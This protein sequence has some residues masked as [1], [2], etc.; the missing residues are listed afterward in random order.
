[1]LSDWLHWLPDLL[2]GLRTSI[3]A[4]VL[5][6][7]IGLPGGFILGLGMVARSP[8]M[9]YLTVS[10][11]ELGRGVP[12]LVVLYLVYFGLPAQGLVLSPFVAAIAGIA[13]STAAYTSEIFR[14]GIMN[15]P[16]GHLEAAQSLGL[17]WRDEVR[18]VVGPQA[19]RAITPALMSY[20]II[21]FQATSLGYAISLPELLTAGYGIGSVTFKFLS[22]FLL[23]GI[24]YAAVSISA[25]HLINRAHLRTSLS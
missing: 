15:V 6:L 10:V 12:L 24:L 18:F 25:S 19:L 2:A 7:L 1:M 22:V 16:R 17:N 9:R 13:F 23:V 3:F 20:A 14:A 5:S 4:A 8:A 11:V 21:I